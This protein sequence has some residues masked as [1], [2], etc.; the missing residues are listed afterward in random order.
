MFQAAKTPCELLHRALLGTAVTETTE[1]TETTQTEHSIFQGD[2]QPHVETE[3]LK[4]SEELFLQ[5]NPTFVDSELKTTVF[6]QRFTTKQQ[7][8]EG[9]R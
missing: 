4:C 5:N 9:K 8:G 1:I 3:M 2:T 7:R 6:L